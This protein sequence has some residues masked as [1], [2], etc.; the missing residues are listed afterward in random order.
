MNFLYKAKDRSSEQHQGEIESA[1][2]HSAVVL[3]RRHGLVVISVTPRPVHQDNFFLRFFSR[4]SFTQLVTVT[5]QLATMVGAGLTLSESI[6]ILAEQQEHKR[7]KK[8][9]EEV[10]DDI[11]G[12]LNLAQSLSRHADIFPPL[13]INLVKS[14]EA[15]GKLD[16][17]LHKLADSLEKEREFRS[18][19]RGAMIYPSVVV[20]MMILVIVIMMTFV[21]PRLTSFYQEAKIELP[22]PTKILIATSSLFVNFWWVL[23][24]IL[25]AAIFM[26]RKWSQTPNGR[27]ALDTLWLKTPIIGKILSNVTLTNFNRTFGLLTSA[28]IPLLESINIVE[29]VTQNSVFKKALMDT[30]LGVERGLSFSAQ[31]LIL[32]VF[33][34]IVGQMVR[35]GEETGKLDE[36]FNKLSDYFESESDHL[37]KNLTVA[38]EPIILIILGV[39]VAFLV[40]S[41]ILPIYRLTTTF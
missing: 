38:I 14:G 4:V 3:L 31:L 33:P 27:L 39:G 16:E 34:R 32:P 10:S 11:K 15:S 8:V 37:V 36:I 7:F 5:R 28:G 30:Y 24:I 9:L 6:D 2:L 1:D 23:I 26:I 22:L 12:G 40:V 13:Y 20:G 18:R 25:S 35:V 19:V 21:I 29:N 17:V 41:I